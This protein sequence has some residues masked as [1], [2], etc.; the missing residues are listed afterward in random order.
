VVQKVREFGGKFQ[1]LVSGARR[2]FEQLGIEQPKKHAQ[3]NG[4]P[5]KRR[6][7]PSA[8]KN[9]LLARREKKSVSVSITWK[10]GATKRIQR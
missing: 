7:S 3:K 2:G 4:G 1:G 10:L 5:Q 9:K 8:G 6:T